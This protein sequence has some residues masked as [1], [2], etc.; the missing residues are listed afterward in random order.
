MQ[1]TYG[2]PNAP[3]PAVALV[4]RAENIN[5]SLIELLNRAQSIANQCAPSGP[6]DVASGPPKQVAERL[7][8]H[9]ADTEGLVKEL[10]FQLNRIVRALLG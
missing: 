4:A 2:A 5:Q 10:D 3:V 6:T 1:Q 9:I 7:W 8:E